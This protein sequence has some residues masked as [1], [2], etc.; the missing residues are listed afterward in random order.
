M[1]FEDYDIELMGEMTGIPEIA[2]RAAID[3]DRAFREAV[4]KSSATHGEH[5]DATRERQFSDRKTEDP[6]RQR[7]LLLSLGL[8]LGD[9]AE[10]ED[11]AAE[12][13]AIAGYELAYMRMLLS[14]MQF[15]PEEE[16]QASEAVGS[17][18]SSLDEGLRLYEE[19]S[20][21][22]KTYER[23]RIIGSM[24]PYFKK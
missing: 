18:I 24:L 2:I 22:E 17:T 12:E 4:E 21:M 8:P 16:R 11:A 15:I 13:A 23:H 20:G 7:R 1:N 19:A 9:E 5:L 3:V 6:V 14:R 10:R